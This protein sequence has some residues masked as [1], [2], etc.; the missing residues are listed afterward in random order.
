MGYTMEEVIKRLPD[1][2]RREV[3]RLLT[4]TFSYAPT[5]GFP[6]FVVAKSKLSRKKKKVKSNSPQPIQPVAVATR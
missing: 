5:R 4:E 1:S 2:K 3:E 6:K